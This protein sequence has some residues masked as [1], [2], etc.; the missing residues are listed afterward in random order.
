MWEGWLKTRLMVTHVR[1]CRP[2]GRHPRQGQKQAVPLLALGSPFCGSKDPT[3]REHQ[4]R[5]VRSFGMSSMPLTLFP[6]PC[7][8]E[9]CQQLRWQHVLIPDAVQRR[10]GGVLRNPLCR[11]RWRQATSLAPLACRVSSGTATSQPG[12]VLRHSSRL[13]RLE[14]VP[15][16]A[17]RPEHACRSALPLHAWQLQNAIRCAWTCPYLSRC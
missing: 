13:A 4:Q 6:A 11:R 12:G 14:P 1:W 8:L 3:G 17:A 16:V 7:H 5:R 15:T 2:T 10:S 9:G